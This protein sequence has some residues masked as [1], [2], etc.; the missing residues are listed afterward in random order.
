M[1][2]TLLLNIYYHKY[3]TRAYQLNRIHK[4]LFSLS[5][6]IFEFSVCFLRFL[7]VRRF[8]F[9]C[10]FEEIVEHVEYQRYVWHI[11][12][13]Q[14]FG[15]ITAF[16]QTE[17]ALCQNDGELNLKIKTMNMKTLHIHSKRH[18]VHRAHTI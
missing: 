10:L 11:N 16:G 1:H 2:E 3:K 13:N 17:N 7:H 5:I 18:R 8:L 6:R 15:N 4:L 9:V 14:Y 12:G